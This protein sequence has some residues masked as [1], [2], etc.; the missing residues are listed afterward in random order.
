MQNVSIHVCSDFVSMLRRLWNHMWSKRD[1]VN[2]NRVSRQNKS[3]EQKFCL[4]WYNLK[5]FCCVTGNWI[6]AVCCYTS[7]RQVSTHGCIAEAIYHNLFSVVFPQQLGLYQVIVPYSQEM[8]LWLPDDTKNQ[9]GNLSYCT[10][11]WGKKWSG[12][13]SQICWTSRSFLVMHPLKNVL[14]RIPE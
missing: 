3:P 8:R 1:I 7:C 9:F 4:F 11:L 13:L 5:G 6:T 2:E 14:N 10:L 12:E